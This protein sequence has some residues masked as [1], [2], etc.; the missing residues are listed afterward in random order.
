MLP[1]VGFSIHLGPIGDA[2]LS[3]IELDFSDFPYSLIFLPSIEDLLMAIGGGTMFLS[4]STGEWSVIW[5]G[6][7]GSLIRWLDDRSL[8]FIDW[9]LGNGQ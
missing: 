2:K 5:L 9:S 6:G 7:W 8:G 4:E 3:A 1:V